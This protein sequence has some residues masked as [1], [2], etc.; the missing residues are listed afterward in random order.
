MTPRANPFWAALKVH[1]KLARDAKVVGKSQG[2]AGA[3]A[4]QG[5][6]QRGNSFR[7]N[8]KR[9]RVSNCAQFQ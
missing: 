2:A 1:P 5:G 6:D 3:D 4:A 7:W 8:V 9:R